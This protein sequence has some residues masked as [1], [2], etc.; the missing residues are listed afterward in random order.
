MT[1]WNA[2][3]FNLPHDEHSSKYVGSWAVSK[4][5][6]L[7]MHQ[8][9]GDFLWSDTSV[10]ARGEKGDRVLAYFC[11]PTIGVVVPLRSGDHLLFNPAVPHTISSQ[12]RNAD[13][14]YCMSLYKKKNLI[15]GNDN[16]LSLNSSQK[17]ILSD[18]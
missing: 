14:I 13:E 4:C 8:D 6:V 1:T 10:H 9:L 18:L 7:N 2:I 12:T 16:L 15:G 5:V 17:K 3:T 11:F